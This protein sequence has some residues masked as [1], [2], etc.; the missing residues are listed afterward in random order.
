MTMFGA[1]MPFEAE[2]APGCE[3]GYVVRDERREFDA[4]HLRHG[5]QCSQAR[6]QGSAGLGFAL[7][8]LVVGLACDPGRVG[9]GLLAHPPGMPG[10]L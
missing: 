5:Q 2:S 9:D 6:V 3:V 10:T 1:V 8:V 7:L 4:E